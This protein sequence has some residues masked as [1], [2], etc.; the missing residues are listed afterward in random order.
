VH[1]R[2]ITVMARPESVDAGVALVRDEAMPALLGMDGFVGLSMLVDR[3]TGRCI[4]TSAWRTPESMAD[5][6]ERM[7][8][9]RR[10]AAELA[11]GDLTIDHWEIA[12]LHRDHT[13]MPGA[14]VRVTWVRIEP[15]RIDR[16]T[17][18]YRMGLVPQIEQYHGFCSASLLV[19]RASGRAVSSVTFDDTTALERSRDQAATLR[20]R[21]SQETGG[22]I[23]DVAEF[24]LALAHLRVPEMA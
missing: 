14:C 7:Q 9:V 13:S 10:R 2:S 22:E 18:V 1:A 15:Q 23:A 12:V 20:Q 19:D 3:A 17:D 16:L 5:S 6:D 4:T 21:G 8:P 24:E 11:G